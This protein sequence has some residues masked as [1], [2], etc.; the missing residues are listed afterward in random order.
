MSDPRSSASSAAK[1]VVSVSAS[2]RFLSNT[3]TKFILSYVRSLDTLGLYPPDSSINFQRIVKRSEFVNNHSRS[4]TSN[5]RY[6]RVF[7]STPSLGT[8]FAPSHLRL[9]L[10]STASN[11]SNKRMIQKNGSLDSSSRKQGY[12]QFLLLSRYELIAPHERVGSSN[13][14][15]IWRVCNEDFV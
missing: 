3:T 2:S 5:S 6:Q 8:F 9:T 13:K 14:R 15:I 1:F 12:S 7:V 4:I 10:P 11:S